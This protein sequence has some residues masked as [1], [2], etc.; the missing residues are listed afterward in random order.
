MKYGFYSKADDSQEIISSGKFQNEEQA[1]LHF[2][3]TKQMTEDI[4]TKL[5]KV[6][7]L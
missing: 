5:Y 2:S 4:F 7:K 1:M 6:V 3:A